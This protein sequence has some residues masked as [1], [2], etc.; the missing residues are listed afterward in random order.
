MDTASDLRLRRAERRI[1]LLDRLVEERNRDLAIT[2]EQASAVQAY[3]VGLNNVLPGAMIGSSPGGTITRANRGVQD[4]LGHDASVLAGT[5]LA[6]LWPAAAD[7]IRRCLAPGVRVIRDEAEW[8]ARDGHVVPVLV[9]GAPHRDLDGRVL[10]LVFVAL[11]V[12]ERRRLEVELR[13]AQKLESLGQLSAG[14]AH[15]INTPMQYLGDNL[16]FIRDA[17]QGLLP[18]LSALDGIAG[19]LPAADAAA[20]RE[21]CRQADLD[22]VRQRLPRSIDSALDGVARVTHIVEAM[23]SF[24]HPQSEKTLVDLNKGL[25]DTLTVARNAYKY[26]AEVVTD[27]GELPMVVCNGGDLNQAFLNLI[28]NAAQAIAQRQHD[29]D[30]RRGTIRIGSRREGADVVIDIVDDGV[31]IPESIRHRIF[32]PFFTTKEVGKGT[33]QGLSISRSIV[34]DHHHGSLTFDSEVGRGTRFTVRLP[35]AGAPHE[36]REPPS[37][38]GTAAPSSGVAS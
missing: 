10:S 20:L 35:I 5:P 14:V 11:D 27:L 8:V 36:A 38:G 6:R 1:E 23:R 16:H 17:I 21:Q 2:Q 18:L 29:G 33:G 28:V 7:F 9:S 32:D 15:E 25:L 13:H 19:A 12:S 31:G 22:F 3:L 26:V 37:S 34:V 24:S 4:L 30:P